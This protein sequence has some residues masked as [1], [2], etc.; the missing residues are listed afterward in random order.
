M[1]TGHLLSETPAKK[2]GYRLLCALFAAYDF[3]ALRRDDDPDPLDSFLEFQEEEM[4]EDLIKLAAICRACDDELGILMSLE[5]N[6]PEGVGE[7]VIN[8]GEIEPLSIREACN[9]IIHARSVI[10][11]FAWSEENP[12]WER[13]FKSQGYQVRN[14]YKVPA[15]K[16]T[17]HQ[18]NGR[19]WI[20]RVELVPFIFATS[21][22]DM[23][24]WKLA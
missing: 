22:W 21:M 23:W 17:G 18:V 24:Q 10:Y 1:R 14:K 3:P 9:K 2:A 16:L 5:S 11:D 13:W 12:I 7:L 8:G 4:S 20:A 15:L 19:E 6:F